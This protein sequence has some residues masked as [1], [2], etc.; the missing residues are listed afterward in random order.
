MPNGLDAS[1][2]GGVDAGGGS[3]WDNIFKDVPDATPA[4]PT[5]VPAAEEKP[6]EP[7]VPAEPSV[8]KPPEPPQPEP[9]A[10]PANEPEASAEVPAPDPVRVEAARADVTAGKKRPID[11]VIQDQQDG[12]L[13]TLYVQVNIKQGSYLLRKHQMEQAKA[14]YDLAVDD[15][16]RHLLGIEELQG[17]RSPEESPAG[18]TPAVKKGPLATTIEE[19]GL[20][21]GIC[22]SL[23]TN[24]PPLETVEALEDWRYGGHQFTKVTGLGDKK[25]ERVAEALDGFWRDNP[26]AADAY[27]T[28]QSGG[29]DDDGA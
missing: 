15:L 26:A 16:S 8:E 10:E 14:A 12:A 7:E 4:K 20:P 11:D 23:R 1:G 17:V 22:E 28:K 21:P 5:P 2:V 24:D 13:R 25:A 29:P 9:P 19:I 27:A 18:P 6:P 3:E